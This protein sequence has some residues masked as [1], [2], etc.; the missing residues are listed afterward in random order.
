MHI[1]LVEQ[2]EWG[3]F[4][5]YFSSINQYSR[6][7]YPFSNQREMFVLNLGGAPLDSLSFAGELA[8]E[9]QHM[10]QWGLD[11][12]EDL[13]LNEAL[14]E[15]ATFMSGVQAD[16]SA[17]GK[18]NAE[19]FAEYPHIQLTARQETSL[20]KDDLSTY[21]H[22]AAERL[23]TIYL[24]EQFGKEFIKNLVNNPEPGVRS[25]QQE[26]DK[27]SGEP[28]F[29]DVYA[30]WRLANFLNDRNLLQGQFGYKGIQPV[31]PVAE[32][33]QIS[34]PSQVA[35]RLPPYGAR[36]Y[37]IESDQPV[38]VS[39]AGST[40]VP[41]TPAEPANGKFVWY[42][43]RG[44]G[45]DFT[46]TRAFDLSG[47]NSVTLEYKTWYELEEFF[48]YAY[49]Q[50]S[51]DGGK[52][53]TILKTANGTEENPNNTSYGWG[54]S[55]ESGGWLAESLDLSAYAGQKILLRFQLVTDYT[56]NRDG[57]MVDEIAIPELGYQDGAEDESGGWQAHGFVRSA[58]LVPAE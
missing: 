27:V 8:H 3:G 13:W 58:N 28:R 56:T 12:N 11:P 15:L 54:Y 49:V 36:Y 41:L 20:D 10:I 22:Y 9:H 6:M 51:V 14:S 26:L 17:S 2:P 16:N 44:D 1:L 33:V 25:I 5:G 55:G 24:F 7:I 4:Y 35:G 18:T 23:F 57:F 38:E 40:M 47:A 39:F 29:D 50:V 53:W 32:T 42:S 34:G 30:S 21:A 31:Q 43:N 46:L 45:S 37:L 48:D 19:V 52:S